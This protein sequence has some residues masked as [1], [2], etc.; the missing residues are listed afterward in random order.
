MLAN[1]KEYIG[2]D[3]SPYSNRGNNIIKDNFSKFQDTK[4]TLIE[5]PY[6]EV[7]EDLGVFDMALTCPPY[8]NIEKYAGDNTSTNKFKTYEDW[9][10]GFYEPLIANTMQRIKPDGIFVLF[11][12]DQKYDLADQAIKIA[13]K[14]GYRSEFEDGY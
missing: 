2:I 8:Y 4:I 12:G 1:V 14:L 9:L 11:V 10:N 3:P 6:E 13:S 5:K 7:T